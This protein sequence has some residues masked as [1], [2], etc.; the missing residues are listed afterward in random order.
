MRGVILAAGDGGRL[1]PYTDTV[2]KTLIEMRGRPLIWYPL[3][4]MAQAGIT[5]IGVVVGHRARQVKEG[6]AKWIPDGVSVEYVYNPEYMGG[7]AVSVRA[8]RDF[9]GDDEFLLSMGDHVIDPSIAARVAA[10]PEHLAVLGV[11]SAAALPGQLSDATRVFVDAYGRLV[12]IGKRLRRWNAV[13]IGVFR[14]QPSV[15]R[16]FDLLYNAV[17]GELEITRVMRHLAAARPS[18]R[19]CDVQGRFWSDVDTIEDYRATADCIARGV[20]GFAPAQA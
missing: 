18:V 8:A 15:F 9:V 2:P 16:A 5:E 12:R 6:I 11:D 17:G 3:T 13:D 10:A 7:N 4:A 1:R 20:A 19:T 14:F